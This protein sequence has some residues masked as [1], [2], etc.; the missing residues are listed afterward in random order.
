[1]NTRTR[2]LLWLGISAMWLGGYIDMDGIMRATITPASVAGLVL[3]TLLLFVLPLKSLP[4]RATSYVLATFIAFAIIKTLMLGLYH[5][6]GL[7]A[8]YYGNEDF[9]PPHETSWRYHE[10]ASFATRVDPSLDFGPHGFSLAQPGFPLYFINDWERYNWRGNPE[11]DDHRRRHLRFSAIWSGTLQIPGDVIMMQLQAER[12]SATVRAGSHALFAENGLDHTTVTGGNTVDIAAEYRRT[13]DGAPRLALRW[14]RDGSHFESIPAHAFSPSPGF[15]ANNSWKSGLHHASWLGWLMAWLGMACLA[16]QWRDVRKVH[17][18]RFAL[19]ALFSLLAFTA[20]DNQLDKGQ[21][22]DAQIFTAGNDW[23]RYET[24]ASDILKGDWLNAAHTEGKPFFMNVAYRYWMA[25]MHALVGEDTSMVA[26]LQQLM[27]SAFILG[28]YAF[29]R[30]A[31]G[32]P[33]A[34]LATVLMLASGEM[35]KYPAMLLD[36]T[37][38]ITLAASMLASL[39]RWR[40]THDSK[41]LWLGAFLMAL[42]I[43]TRANFLPFAVI[44]ALWVSIPHAGQPSWRWSRGVLMIM[45]GA[46]PLL[47]TGWRNAV[48]TGEW[49]WMPASGGFN[50][51]I[52]NHPPVG[53]SFH[54]FDFPPIPPA[55]EQARIAIDYIMAEPGAFL[56]RVGYKLAYLFGIVIWKHEVAWQILVPTTLALTGFI[57]ALWRNTQWRAERLLLGLWVAMNF[58]SLCLVF[59]WVYGWRLSGPT[60]P[61]IGVLGALALHDGWH[62]AKHLLSRK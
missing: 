42:A 22:H 6:P 28:F 17:W 26:W 50:L 52:G 1:M 57:A 54:P 2:I 21:E 11:K 12:G 45:A 20:M 35:L 4:E 23:M 7:L 15:T 39:I 40:H 41:L 9:T 13:E 14:S 44:A 38:S 3:T 43:A 8:S 37:F 5:P 58:A 24:Q 46:L 34:L 56:Y 62:L 10:I 27:M 59:P 55:H 36:T 18:G 61:A 33:L 16:V 60:L 49:T 32:R 53:D 47:F 29:T 31:W 48:V 25:G 30:H 51:W 19:L